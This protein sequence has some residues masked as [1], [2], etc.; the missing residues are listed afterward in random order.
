MDCETKDKNLHTTLTKKKITY[1]NTTTYIIIDNDRRHRKKPLQEGSCRKALLLTTTSR[2]SQSLPSARLFVESLLFCSTLFRSTLL[3]CF[4]S[5]S[6]CSSH[7]LF[8]ALLCIFNCTF[9]THS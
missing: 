7:V 9:R 6:S 3:S 4:S 8:I 1:G 5:F 2:A